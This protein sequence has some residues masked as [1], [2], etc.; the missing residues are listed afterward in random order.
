MKRSETGSVTYHI[1][2]NI[3]NLGSVGGDG[4]T[5]H[6]SSVETQPISGRGKGEI[7]DYLSSWLPNNPLSDTLRKAIDIVDE[8]SLKYFKININFIFSLCRTVHYPGWG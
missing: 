6:L 5:S 2:G 3:Q 4:N 8:V 7:L 1:H